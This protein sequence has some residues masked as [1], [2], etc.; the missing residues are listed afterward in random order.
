[1]IEHILIGKL[2]FFNLPQLLYINTK[3]KKDEWDD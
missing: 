1:M 2:G 3:M